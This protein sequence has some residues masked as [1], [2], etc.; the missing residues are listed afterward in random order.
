MRG[1]GHA[2]LMLSVLP[3]ML[4]S[5]PPPAR[6]VERLRG[7]STDGIDVPPQPTLDETEL[8]RQRAF[9]AVNRPRRDP[10]DRSAQ[11][12]RRR[13]RSAAKARRGF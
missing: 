2:L 11:R 12:Q 4:L 6:A 5:G 13:G 10:R 3:E 8:A 1:F 9:A 7:P